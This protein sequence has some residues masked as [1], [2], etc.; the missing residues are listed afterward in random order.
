[1]VGIVAIWIVAFM[2]LPE[3]SFHFPV[4]AELH[5]ILLQQNETANIAR[6]SGPPGGTLSTSQSQKT[7]R[8]TAQDYTGFVVWISRSNEPI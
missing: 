2:M 6:G 1:M 8:N 3:A 7:H 4:L 5:Y